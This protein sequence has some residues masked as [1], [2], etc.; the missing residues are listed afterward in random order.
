MASDR[1]TSV[2]IN[3][4]VISFSMSTGYNINKAIPVTI[5]FQHFEVLCKNHLCICIPHKYPI[6]QNCVVIALD[7]KKLLKYII[8]MLRTNKMLTLL[9]L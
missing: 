6:T 7:Q 1:K 4:P 3:G 5:T 9:L 8:S 2:V